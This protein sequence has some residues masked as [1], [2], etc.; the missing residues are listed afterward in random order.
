LTEKSP[1]TWV[2]WLH[3]ST[4]AERL[5]QDV[6]N[7]LD[8]LRVRGRKDSGAN[9][10]GLL[11]NWLRN[12]K[13]GSWLVILDNVDDAQIIQDPPS[14]GQEGRSQKRRVNYIPSCAHGA[15]LVTS[16]YRDVATKV[17]RPSAIFHVGPMDESDA[18]AMMANKLEIP[19]DRDETIH[20][21][22]ALSFM[23]LALS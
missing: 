8:E 22:R 2:L 16:R 11:Q 10:F 4:A 1:E 14:K 12:S 20:L 9:I 15:V 21:V 3:A 18:L 7:T 19:C 17:V 5:K 13:H 6:A 23:P